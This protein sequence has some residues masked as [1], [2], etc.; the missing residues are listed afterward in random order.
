MLAKF[1]SLLM[2]TKRT[3][4]LSTNQLFS[5]LMKLSCVCLCMSPF[6]NRHRSDNQV[7]NR[8]AEVLIDRK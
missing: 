1:E 6:Q 8:K 2:M 3:C 7:N 4:E 5:F